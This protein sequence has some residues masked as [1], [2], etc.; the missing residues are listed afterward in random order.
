MT[1]G[2]TEAVWETARA[3]ASRINPVAGGWFVA[4][5]RQ[6]RGPNVD[7]AASTSG[8]RRLGDWTLAAGVAGVIN[9]NFLYRAS[10]E[11]EVSRRAIA[12]TV[13]SLGYR[14]LDFRGSN[15]H[16]LQPAVTWNHS[17]G[18]V[19]ARLY[20]T[21]KKQVTSSHATITGLISTFLDVHPRFRLSGAVAHGDRIFDVASLPTANATGQSMNVRARV[22]VTQ[23]DFIEVGFGA[24]HEQP[25]FDQRTVSLTYRRA[26]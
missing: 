19:Q 9:P 24:A 8:Y 11:T 12:T 5:E 6:H 21:R 16:Q 3:Q 18:E 13:L 4:V 17:R 20:V 10:L 23:R 14:L 2:R 15:V 26:F 25:S 7:V 22:G 1:I